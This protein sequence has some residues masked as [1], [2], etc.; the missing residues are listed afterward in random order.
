VIIDVWATWCGL[1][2]TQAPHFEKMALKYKNIRIV[3]LSTYINKKKGFNGAKNKSKF[4]PQRLLE[5]RD[6]FAADY[7]VEG[8][9]RFILIDQKGNFL[10]SNVP[11]PSESLLE[12]ILPKR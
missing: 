3:A 7:N 5:N 2:K 4:I 10:N 11:F 8:I 9:T 1:C 12:I 6:K